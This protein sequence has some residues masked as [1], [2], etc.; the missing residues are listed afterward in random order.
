M[1]KMDPGEMPVVKMSQPA[2]IAVQLGVTI[3]TLDISLTSTALPAISAGLG[4]DPEST[5]WIINVYYLAVIAALL[6]LAALGEIYG[7]RRIFFGGLVAFALGS[8]AAGLSNSLPMLAIARALVGVGTASVSATTP[9]LIRT[10]YPPS[11]L[12][13]G[14]GV[15]ALVVS[16]AFSIGPTATSAILSIATWPW[17]FLMNVPLAFLTFF[18]REARS[19]ADAAQRSALRGV[20]G[21]PL[22]RHARRPDLR[23]SW[24]CAPLE[25]AADHARHRFRGRL[26]L[27]IRIRSSGSIEG[28]PVEL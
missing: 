20:G 3:V 24:N 15:Y 1:T 7:H 8:L 9:A 2:L 5:I 28:R 23:D 26:R 6:P 12:G 21:V 22:R 18:D 19:A 25:L 13:R 27:S 14:L 16:V 4:T 17:L 10:L 11:R